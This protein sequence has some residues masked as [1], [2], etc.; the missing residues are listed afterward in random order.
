M[1]RL[2]K[3]PTEERR[4]RIQAELDLLRERWNAKRRE[5]ATTREMDPADPMIPHLQAEIAN[6]ARKI[7]ELERTLER[8]VPP[9]GLARQP[10]VVGVG[11]RLG[12]RW[13]DGDE[14]VYLLV[15]P[16]EADHRRGWI[17][18]ESPVGLGLLGRRSGEW[19]EVS[20]PVGERRLQITS[21]E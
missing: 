14:G 4:Q 16:V 7:A 8:L 5:H 6:L 11:S 20:T 1:S 9:D 12:V 3:P 15:D 2:L 10:G 18:T 21:I 17:S 13:D 19:V